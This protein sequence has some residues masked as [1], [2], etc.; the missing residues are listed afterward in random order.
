VVWGVA[1]G[2]ASGVAL[3]V[4]SGVGLTVHLWLP[5]ALYPFLTVWNILLYQLDKKRTGSQPSLLRWH[6]AFWYEWQYIPL[7][8]LEKHVLLVMER[9]PAEGK[10]AIEYLNTSRQRWAA[11]AAQIELD[12][13]SL[14][15]CADVEA[16]RNAHRSLVISELENPA[17]A[18]LRIFSRISEDTDAALNQ[19][20]VYNQRLALSAVADRVYAQLQDLTRSSDKYAARFYP[21]AKS[22]CHTVTEYADELAK[23]VELRQEID[24]PYITG[25]PL[26]EQ[27]QI[28]VKPADI[29]GTE[30]GKRIEQLLLDRRRPPLLLYGQRRM[31]KTSLLN[32]L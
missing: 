28:F 13:R 18:M 6:S 1:V 26:N 8:D 14:E 25:I 9:N 2:V 4:A 15:R 32:N 3:G 31:G 29:S 22:W 30:I 23:A 27:Q 10:A 21:I 20:S 19:E 5:A 16:I 17:G 24:N 12:A 11:Q 7:Y